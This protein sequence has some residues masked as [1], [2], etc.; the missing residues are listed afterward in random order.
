MIDFT[1][2]PN[3]ITSLGVPIVPAG[4]PV[5]KNSKSIFTDF[6]RGADGNPGTLSKPVKTINEALSR[7]RSY[8]NDTIY[9]ISDGG[10]L[11]EDNEENSTFYTDEPIIWNKDQ[12][13]LVGLSTQSSLAKTTS[14]KDSVGSD[15][16]TLF[17]VEA[18]HCFFSNVR[19]DLANNNV[20]EAQVCLECGGLGN[21]FIN[22]NISGAYSN[23]AVANAGTR[24]LLLDSG[25]GIDFINSSIGYEASANE[26]TSEAQIEFKNTFSST[27][28][29]R[30]NFNDCSVIT[31]TSSAT[32]L[33]VKSD[34]ASDSIVLPVRFKDTSFQN[35]GSAEMTA[36]VSSHA[37]LE[38]FILLSTNAD[39]EMTGCANWTAADV[40][41]VRRTGTDGKYLNAY[42]P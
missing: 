7:A 26:I 5:G 23:A 36:A 17:K 27:F 19:M 9:L 38:S 41:E 14:I 39:T 31:K 32:H 22:C 30:Y 11:E 24:A 3:G 25:G 12:V 33:F 29:G 21:L 1:N 4:V 13:H 34:D 10:F 2:F 28:C 40:P 8:R 16:S 20:D 42:I 37:S 35:V 18:D 15:I 6:R